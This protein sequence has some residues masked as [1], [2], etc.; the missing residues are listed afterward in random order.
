M[1]FAFCLK[2]FRDICL[3]NINK[4]QAVNTMKINLIRPPIPKVL[5]DRLDPPIG[6]ALLGTVLKSKGYEVEI[7]DFT[8]NK[9]V[10]IHAADVYGISVWTGSFYQAIRIR[11]D[12]RK[13][14]DAPIIAGGP[15]VSALPEQCLGYFDYVFIGESE[16]TLPEKIEQIADRTLDEKIIYSKRLQDLSSL[17]QLDILDCT[18]FGLQSV[19]ELL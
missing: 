2:I 16:L 6:L 1:S 10:E 14:S 4:K 19:N 18:P 11:D 17:P 8:G 13:L 9:P 15:H 3:N 12:I 7:S 5:D